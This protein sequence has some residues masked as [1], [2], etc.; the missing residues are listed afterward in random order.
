MEWRSKKFAR[1]ISVICLALLLLLLGTGAF[2]EVSSERT[3]LKNITDELT[4]QKQQLA[5]TKKDEQAALSRLAEV[6]KDLT[7]ASQQLTK[8]TQDV[9]KNETKIS[10]LAVELSRSQ[11]KLKTLSNYL[12]E[13]IVEVYKEGGGRYLD[14]LFTSKSMSDFV[15][16]AYYFGKLLERDITLIA[17]I[18]REY[19]RSAVKK[20]DLQI[21]TSEIK[22]LAQDIQSKK[23]TIVARESEQKVLYNQLRTRRAEYERRIAELEKSSVELEGL[24][25]KKLA[26]R[27]KEGLK[28]PTSSGQFTW[29]VKGRITSTFGYRRHPIWG[30]SNFHTGLDIANAYGTSISAADSGEVIFSGWWDGYGKAIVIDH[31]K[32]MST[33][34][35]HL[36]RIYVRVGNT[37]KKGQVVGLLGSS[38]YSTGP[39]LHFEV[40]QS[41][42]PTNPQNWL[43]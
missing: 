38:G 6:R 42:K 39:H 29:P 23:K 19:R 22:Q 24:I 21:A 10:G 12:E 16:R 1:G 15:N 28:S 32:G 37:V 26:Q 9:N 27:A 13:K 31:G 25:K 14:L 5:K 41:G 34:Y 8:A 20:R 11:K 33:V 4:K 43:P 17:S 3:K 2:G 35:G 30:G 7:Q 18:E 40:R 36:S